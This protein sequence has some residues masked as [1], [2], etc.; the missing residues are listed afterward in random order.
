MRISNDDRNAIRQAIYDTLSAHIKAPFHTLREAGLQADLRTFLQSRL[1]PS[2]VSVAQPVPQNQHSSF[3]WSG[4]QTTTSRV[5]LEMKIRS[6]SSEP[7]T[8]TDI[9]ILQSK[10]P[11]ILQWRN[12]GPG[13]VVS[14]ISPE[15]VIAAIELK[16]S[17]ATPAERTR[18]IKDINKLIALTDIGIFGFFVHINKSISLYGN[19]QKK[20]QDYTECLTLDELQKTSDMVT[21]NKLSEGLQ[22]Q[23][24]VEIWDIAINDG[25]WMPRLRSTM[26]NSQAHFVENFNADINLFN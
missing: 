2:T 11:A 8:V 21:K 17:P 15:Q 10:N 3:A 5:A 18:Y 4:G 12:G 14:Q 23:P 6:K 16:A 26:K 25:K 9:V 24:S 22:H 13:D 19:H 1:S 20:P 7:V